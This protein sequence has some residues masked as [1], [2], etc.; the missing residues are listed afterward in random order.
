MNSTPLAW[1]GGDFLP[2]AE[3]SIPVHD[4]G[5]VLGATVTEQLRTF[6]GCLFRL[7]EHL[8]RWERGLAALGLS[9]PF[10]R[11]DLERA[12]RKLVERNHELLPPGGDLGLCVL[13]TP[14]PYPTLAGEGASGACSQ[15][16]PTLAMHTYALPFPFWRD[17]YESGQA[18]VISSVR[19]VPETCW[20][21]GVKHRSRLHYY[22]ADQEAAARQE[23]ARALLLDEAG[24]VNETSTANLLAYFPQRGLVSPR[25]EHVLPGVSMF[26][27]SDI[28]AR[29][30]I[31][32][33][34]DDIRP[35]Q[36]LGDAAGGEAA[37]RS[38][39]QHAPGA[40]EVAT[41]VLL[42]STP[43]CLLPVT[44]IDGIPV[45]DGRPGPIY[46]RLLAGWN[47]LTGLDVAQQGQS[48]AA[49]LPAST[50]RL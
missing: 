18:L 40:D 41:E 25:L 30:G 3:L 9:M 33:S 15:N 4:T 23:G 31:R 5:F 22:L 50:E 43:W 6:N 1:R 26:A 24:R 32:W 36:L 44:S 17:K 39:D 29:L 48:F 21:R 8:E 7:T 42:T 34:F 12:A 47:E 14:G 16:K 19:Q 49:R 45:G 37:S 27:T 10:S 2:A 13:A 46:R 11:G 20:P 38:E 28:A 35:K